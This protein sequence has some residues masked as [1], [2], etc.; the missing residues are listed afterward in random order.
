LEISKSPGPPL[1]LISTFPSKLKSLEIPTFDISLAEKFPIGLKTLKITGTKTVLTGELLEK[2]PKNLTELELMASYNPIPPNCDLALLFKALPQ[3]LTL[4]FLTGEQPRSE[5]DAEFVSC[6]TPTQSSLLLP[7]SITKLKMGYLNFSESRMSDWILGLPTGLVA[8]RLLIPS[9][10]MDMFSSLR[11]LYHL[12][13]L[14]VQVW[15]AP[16]GGWAQYTSFNSLPRKLEQIHLSEVNDSSSNSLF[17][18]DSFKGA[19]RY[20]QDISIPASPFLTEA[21]LVHLPHLQWLQ[22]SYRS[23]SW[24]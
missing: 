16:E 17:T 1:Q 3:S 22:I 2:I 11:C 12:K 10:Y 8:L 14:S 13:W 21:C 5:S 9:P 7:R 20:L 15:K 6:P 19:P 24:F 4:L 23:P 18:D